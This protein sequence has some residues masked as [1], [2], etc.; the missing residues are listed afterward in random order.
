MIATAPL[1]IATSVAR[2]PLPLTRQAAPATL[3]PRGEGH[4]M[5]GLWPPISVLPRSAPAC[6]RGMCCEQQQ[7]LPPPRSLFATAPIA[8]ATAVARVHAR[9]VPQALR[10]APASD[11]GAGT[12]VPPAGAGYAGVPCE[13]NHSHKHCRVWEGI[14]H[15]PQNRRRRSIMLAITILGLADS[16]A[17]IP[18]CPEALL[19]T[20][21]ASPSS[22]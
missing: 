21:L 11:Q 1:A 2:V 13:R 6:L 8:I 4:Q 9:H 10:M 22:R 17:R 18:W 16:P 15:R 14:S 19:A 20:W 7:P 5:S 3:S 12:I